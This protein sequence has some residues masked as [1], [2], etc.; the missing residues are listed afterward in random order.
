MII[1]SN[2][3]SKVSFDIMFANVIKFITLFFGQ[4]KNFEIKI[5]FDSLILEK[6]RHREEKLENFVTFAINF[7]TNY[8]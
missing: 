6:V 7:Q 2:N 8:F 1:V 4:K 5:L 3:T